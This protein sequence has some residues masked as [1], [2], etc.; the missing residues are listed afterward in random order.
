MDFDDGHDDE[1]SAAAIARLAGVSRA[2]VTGWRAR[3]PDFPKPVGGTEARPTFSTKAVEAWLAETGKVKQLA[4]AGRTDTGTQ[5]TPEDERLQR[6]REQQAEDGIANLTATQLLGRTMAALLP[7]T[8]SGNTA[9]N[10]DDGGRA[11]PVVLDPACGDATLLAAVA[12]RFGGGVKLVGQDLQDA[13]A[14][15]TAYVLRDFAYKLPYEVRVGD[16]LREDRLADYLGA[17][18][19]VVCDPPFNPAPWPWAELSTDPRWQ[20]GTPGPRDGELAWVQHC[21]AH[22]RPK[23]VAVIAVSA[24]TCVQASGQHVR[25]ALVRSGVLRD[26]IALPSGLAAAPE[27]EACLWV[28]QRPY[29]TPDHA[30]VRMVDLSRLGDAADVPHEYAAWQRLFDGTDPT[31][32]TAVPRLEL[33][34]NDVN[35]LPA[36]RIT[37]RTAATADDFAA[38]TAR[39]QHLY[40]DF[41]RSLPRFSSPPTAPRHTSVTLSELERLGALTI[42]PRDTTP[43]IGDVIV[44]T[45]GLPPVVVRPEH[46]EADGGIVQVQEVANIAHVIEIDP[47]RLDPDFVAAFLRA[48]ANLQP[49]T[50]TLGMLSRDD[51]RRCRL[52]HLPVGEQRSYGDAFRHL[53][54]LDDVATALAKTCTHVIDQTFHALATGALDPAF[55][56]ADRV[57]DDE[58]SSR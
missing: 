41:S 51:L 24:R 18:A 7:R 26:V 32:S 38:V 48:D 14:E 20:F 2:A 8:T 11:L 1:V 5:L 6:L 17:A 42:R 40:R 52:P 13:A 58:T 54:T 53:L 37:H 33:L 23:G 12:D 39:L 43:R 44:R 29:G 50:N 21:Y 56:A 45:L 28:L 30:P 55:Q 9:D 22:L 15:R 31:V 4:K 47:E 46:P 27:A 35:L 3:Y 25:A 16:S 36:R 57:P 49:V 34:D 10:G 19:A